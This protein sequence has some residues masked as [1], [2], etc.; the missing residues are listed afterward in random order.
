MFTIPPH[1]IAL[2]DR[3]VTLAG[4]STLLQIL[5]GKR[6]TRSNA[7][8]LGQDVFF[9]TPPGVTYLGQPALPLIRALLDPP[10]RRTPS[11]AKTRY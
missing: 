2:D 1:D 4:K 11:E 7:Q 5:A 3:G 6:L 10:R 9:Q 8:V